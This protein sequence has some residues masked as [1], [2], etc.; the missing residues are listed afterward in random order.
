MKA[1]TVVILLAI[2]SIGFALRLWSPELAPFDHETT[3]PLRMASKIA[4]GELLT[5]SYAG[6]AALGPLAYYLL[7]IPIYISSNPLA[8]VIFTALLNFIAL[9]VL[10]FIANRFFGEKAALIATAL[11]ATNPWAVFYSRFVWNPNFLPLFSIILFGGLLYAI[12][13]NEKHIITAFA[14]FACMIQIHSSALFLLPVLLFESIRINKKYLLL[15]FLTAG[16][17]LSPVIYFNLTNDFSGIT[18]TFAHASHQQQTG[19]VKNTLESAGISAMLS[20]N[21]LGRYIF[22]TEY[23]TNYVFGKFLFIATLL[24]A[25]IFLISFLYLFIKLFNSFKKNFN[26]DKNRLLL[27][28]YIAVPIVIFIIYRQNLAPHYYLIIQPMLFL[29]IGV[30]FSDMLERYRKRIHKI[31]AAFILIAIVLANIFTV[32][33]ML[34]FAEKNGGINGTYGIPYKDKLAVAEFIEKGGINPTILSYKANMDEYLYILDAK[35][36]NYT[37]KVINSLSELEKIKNAYLI[38]DDYSYSVGLNSAN[39]SDEEKEKLSQMDGIH[40]NKLKVVEL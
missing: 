39:L 6:G 27:F 17:I 31:A 34:T 20:T 32:Y 8:P 28:L 35:K 14:S 24:G 33:S 15:A 3:D 1:K 7:A 5:E 4:H 29:M 40:F 22:G 10:F 13:K 2:L 38:L 23:G 18:D 37:Y 9:I 21:Y 25:G 36:I 16:I 12:N 11:F 30:F 26:L 19:I